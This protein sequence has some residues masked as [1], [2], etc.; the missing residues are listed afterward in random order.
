M[1]VNSSWRVQSG[2]Y[3]APSLVSR[4]YNLGF[5]DTVD[6]GVDENLFVDVIYINTFCQSL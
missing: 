4:G 1:D 2:P 3:G 6:G 5:S